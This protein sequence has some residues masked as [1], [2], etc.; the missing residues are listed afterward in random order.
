MFALRRTQNSHNWLDKLGHLD[1]SLFSIM[2]VML[3]F[4]KFINN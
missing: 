1:S 4:L 2:V 3:T